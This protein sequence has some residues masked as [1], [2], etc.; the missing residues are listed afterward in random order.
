VDAEVNLDMCREEGVQIVRRFSGGGAVYQDFGNLNYSIAIE[1]DHPFLKGMNIIE[2]FRALSYGVVEGLKEFGIELI[3]DPPS[4][5]LVKDKKISGNAQSRRKGIIFHH[6]TLLVNTDLDFLN[7]ILCVPAEKIASGKVT[8]RK[9]LVTNLEDEI[10]CRIEIA[11]V[12][13]MLL[14]GF[15]K[16]FSIK[17]IPNMLTPEEKRTAD[18]LYAEKYSK[19]EWNFWR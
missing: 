17:L 7:R 2:T 6:G 18:T 14:Q 16:V 11:K 12:K 10:G 4:D 1:A 5:L 19:K 15:E 8:S 13:E 3:F 9:R